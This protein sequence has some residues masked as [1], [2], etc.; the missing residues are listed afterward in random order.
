[1][2]IE[3]PVEGE[4]IAYAIRCDSEG[5]ERRLL[6]DLHNRADFM[7]EVWTACRELRDLLLGEEAT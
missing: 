5:D 4:A 7:G 3:V 6:L 2:V 1:L